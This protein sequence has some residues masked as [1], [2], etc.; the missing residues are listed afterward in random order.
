MAARS[1]IASKSFWTLGTYAGSAAV[2]FS[3]NIVLSHLLGPAALGVVVVAQAVRNGAELL[4]DMGFEQNVVHSPA[5]DDVRFLNT[6]WTLQIVRGLLIALVVAALA[7]FLAH[8][9]RIGV[10]ILLAMST[11][12]F[13]SSLMS[14]SIFS[15]AKN[16]NV[17]DRNLL[18]L[19][20]ETAGLV[21][22]AVLAFALRNIW[23]PIIGIL[24]TL[25]V[26]SAISY[27]FPHPK[28]MLVLDR[29]HVRD[30]FG[31][32]KW[33]ML[34]SLALY[35]AIYIDRLFLG[36]VVNLA[37]LGVYGLARAISDLPQ[38]VAGRLAFQI[39]FPFLAQNR[40]GLDASARA[41][42]SR[43]RSHFLMLVGLGIGTLGP[44]SDWAVK[45]LYGGR[46]LAAGWMLSILMTGGWIGTLNSLNGAIVFGK[47][48]PQSVGLANVV[49]IGVMAVALT[50]GFAL[51]GLAGAVAA[52]PVAESVRY[53]MLLMAQ[54]RAGVTFFRQ[55]VLLT[56]GLIGLVG[57][58]VALRLIVGLGTP[59][60]NMPLR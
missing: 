40:E 44:W 10:A 32:S 21:F 1:S 33:I 56:L 18:E 9:Y 42:L 35:A 14:T 5:G 55:D 51:W 17:R 58:W 47:G 37:M 50:G 19:A 7:P 22:I 12:P 38:T 45:L 6:V 26:R 39:V 25:V 46:Y 57:G 59:W 20:A 29:V 43:T 41:E 30:I 15:L 11:A 8:F 2:R 34:S 53:G 28:H 54:R 49:R 24:L 36:R 3:T 27:W 60:D 4:T 23:A 48:R 31:F 16:L 13:I 52:L